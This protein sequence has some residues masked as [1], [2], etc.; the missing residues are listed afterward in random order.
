MWKCP[1]CGREF[2]HAQQHHFCSAP[3]ETIEAYIVRQSEEVQ[4]R[5]R[6]VYAA[7]KAELPDAT[8]KISWQM[9]TFWKGQNLI[10]F[11]AAKKHIGL[12]PGDKATT[13]F[14]EKLA[15]FKT[16]KG[17]I[18]LPNNQPLPLALIGEIARWCG[19]A[20]AK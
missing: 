14:V 11:A 3:P 5:L 6:E 9:P 10:H 2:E 8:E 4:P 15:G 16:S 13:V 20:N 18:R 7:I 1:N 12:Y 19:E 17:S